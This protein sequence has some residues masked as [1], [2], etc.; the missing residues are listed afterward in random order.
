M[1]PSRRPEITTDEEK[2]EY[3]DALSPGRQLII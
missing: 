1:P 3:A 2:L